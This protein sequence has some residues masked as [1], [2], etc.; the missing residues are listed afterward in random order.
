L[1]DDYRITVGWR[2]VSPLNIPRLLF[3]DAESWLFHVSYFCAI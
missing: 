3:F 1:I 2:D